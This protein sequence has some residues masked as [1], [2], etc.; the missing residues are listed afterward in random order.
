MP[1][2]RRPKRSQTTNTKQ[3]IQ[4]K[5]KSASTPNARQENVEKKRIGNSAQAE[6]ATTT[7]KFPRNRATTSPARTRGRAAKAAAPAQPQEQEQANVEEV[8][9]KRAISVTPVDKAPH[10]LSSRIILSDSFEKFLEIPQRF[11]DELTQDAKTLLSSIL[12]V[13]LIKPD[14]CGSARIAEEILSKLKEYG[15]APPSTDPEATMGESVNQSILEATSRVGTSKISKADSPNGNGKNRLITREQRLRAAGVQLFEM[16]QSKD[17]ELISDIISPLEGQESDK[18]QTRWDQD[19]RRS[20]TGNEAMVQ[21]TIM[22]TAMNRFKEQGFSGCLDFNMELQW[23]SP[24]PPCKEPK[25][26][27]SAPKPDAC[28]GFRPTT[29]VDYREQLDGLGDELLSHMLPEKKHHGQDQGRAFP[30]LLLEVKGGSAP[31][32]GRDVH[33][34]FLNDASYALYNIWQFMKDS[35]QLREKYFDKV[36]VFTAG[37]NSE[38]FWIRVHRAYQR[39]PRDYIQPGYPL[40]FGFESVH[41]VSGAQYTQTYVQTML[42]RVMHWGSTQLRDV[43]RLAVKDAYER[44]FKPILPPPAQETAIDDGNSLAQ[45]AS[46]EDDN[47]R[48]RSGGKRKAGPHGKQ[49]AKKKKSTPGQASTRVATGGGDSFVSTGMTEPFAASALGSQ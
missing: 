40:G 26:A 48:T 8:Q 27:L 47:P 10:A 25:L 33:L 23:E 20:R 12:H 31:A 17:A 22:M 15:Y 9:P 18:I 32:A 5:A 6:N 37:C 11:R 45:S 35:D 30:F 14:Y 28:I 2:R 38:R 43:L 44:T 19:I 4:G 3:H 49:G 34:Q 42:S 24:K 29:L 46:A 16:Q 13:D 41:N 39:P 36:R 1:P 21:R 7:S